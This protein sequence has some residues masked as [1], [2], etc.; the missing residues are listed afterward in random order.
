VENK[1]R[2]ILGFGHLLKSDRTIIPI[3]EEAAKAR[4]RKLPVLSPRSAFSEIGA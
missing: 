3:D 2:S 1:K 4:A